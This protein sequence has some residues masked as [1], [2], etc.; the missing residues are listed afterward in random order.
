MAEMFCLEGIHYMVKYL[1]KAVGQG[2]NL[3]ARYW[4]SY[5]S[6]I[7]LFANN[8]TDGCAANHG[9]AF[10]IG[11]VYH[12]SHGLS[13]AIV[14]PYVFPYVARAE[15]DRMP[16]LAQAFGLDIAG[17]TNQELADAITEELVRLNRDVGCLIP[18][19]KFGGKMEDIDHLIDET[20]AQTRVMG[21]S[22]WKLT[23]QELREIFT[24]AM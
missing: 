9:L 19:S 6:S 14:L 8:L 20:F 15:L 24:K 4:V 21:H 22:S 10:A 7:G 16:R 18:L 17:K 5:A 12:I 3:E 11:G 23:E 1:R 2:D 13:N